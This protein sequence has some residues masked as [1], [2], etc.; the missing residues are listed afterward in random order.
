MRNNNILSSKN[1]STY[2]KHTNKIHSKVSVL[3]LQ[4]TT[5]K[6]YFIKIQGGENQKFLKFILLTKR[7]KE[8]KNYLN[9][10]CFVLFYCLHFVLTS[11]LPSL[12]KSP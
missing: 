5:Q 12:P 1:L 10:I 9:F 2:I 6:D 8:K 4:H 11:I 7:P 3:S